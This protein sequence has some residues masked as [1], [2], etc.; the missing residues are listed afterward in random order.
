MQEQQSNGPQART[1]ANDDF[2]V[3]AGSL[4]SS[5]GHRK[6]LSQ[7]VVFLEPFPL[8]APFQVPLRASR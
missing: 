1:G 2:H 7:I 6:G 8:P 4:S 5:K 3:L